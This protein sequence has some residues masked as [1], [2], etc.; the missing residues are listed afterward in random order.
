M[1]RRRSGRSTSG[2]TSSRGASGS[3]ARRRVFPQNGL[4]RR[5][6]WMTGHMYIFPQYDF[7]SNK[8]LPTGAAPGAIGSS[9]TPSPATTS[10]T[11][12]RRTAAAP[13]RRRRIRTTIS[14]TISTMA[15]SP[16][17]RSA[18]RAGRTGLSSRRRVRPGDRDRA[19]PTR[20]DQPRR[21]RRPAD[22]Q[23]QQR[24]HGERSR[25]WRPPAGRA[26]DAFWRS[27]RPAVT[28]PGQRGTVDRSIFQNTFTGADHD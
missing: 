11:C 17:A 8:W 27:R 24:L 10:S 14:T 20:S 7:R 23:L 21:G 4:R 3:P 18:R 19:I 1:R 22:P 9:S 6:H 13:A 25:R 5:R 2:A 15:A 26:A 28:A 12:S 16:R